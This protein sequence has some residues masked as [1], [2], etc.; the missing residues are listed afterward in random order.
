M[1]LRVAIKTSPMRTP[2]TRV[3]RCDFDRPCEA[4]SDDGDD[5]SGVTAKS[6][7]LE[8]SQ[9]MCQSSQKDIAYLMVMVGKVPVG[10][11]RVELGSRR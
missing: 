3:A 7:L 10:N 9:D 11:E 2:M 8:R 1:A 5:V 6:G 4:E